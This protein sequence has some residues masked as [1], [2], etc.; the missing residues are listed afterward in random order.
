MKIK[1]RRFINNLINNFFDKKGQLILFLFVLFSIAVGIGAYSC[2]MI[3]HESLRLSYSYFEDFIYFSNSGEINF[4]S[5]CIS[6][7]V[8]G[9]KYLA[10]IGIAGL[11][12]LGLPISIGAVCYKGFS[13]GYAVGCILRIYGLSQLRLLL[14]GA[15]IPNVLISMLIILFAAQSIAVSLNL[16]YSSGKRSNYSIRD[17]IVAFLIN[18]IVYCIILLLISIIC[19]ALTLLF[20]SLG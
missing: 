6:L 8:S 7:L 5:Y 9:I 14:L 20:M 16:F 3:S 2:S 13:V 18:F 15:I 12:V 17:R 4:K 10:I 19:S 1:L 11:C